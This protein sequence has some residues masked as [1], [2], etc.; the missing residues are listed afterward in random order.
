[1]RDPNRIKPY[2]QMIEQVWEKYP[3]LRF[4]QLV[5]NVLTQSFDYYKEDEETYQMFKNTYQI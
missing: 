2:L 4:S 3:D 5:L 1:M